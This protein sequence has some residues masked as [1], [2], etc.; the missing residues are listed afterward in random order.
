MNPLQLLQ[1]LYK[2]QHLLEG[3]L[4][5]SSVVIE[6]L[7]GAERRVED[8]E[9]RVQDADERT[10]AA[11][12]KYA[13]LRQF[14]CAALL[15][16]VQRLVCFLSISY[17]NRTLMTLMFSRPKSNAWKASWVSSPRTTEMQRTS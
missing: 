10:N 9:Q 1:S 3:V 17:D 13:A 8:A 11:E 16:E 15:S 14:I 2:S 7:E 5:D 4:S 6:V 12:A